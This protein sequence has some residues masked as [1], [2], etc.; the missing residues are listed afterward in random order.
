[1]GVHVLATFEANGS[2]SVKYYSGSPCVTKQWITTERVDKETLASYSCDSKRYTI[3]LVQ[4]QRYSLGFQQ[5][6]QCW[7]YWHLRRELDNY[8][9]GSEVR[10]QQ[11]TQGEAADAKQPPVD[12]SHPII[13]RNSAPRLGWD[14]PSDLCVILDFMDDGDLRSLLNKYEKFG[15]PVGFNRQKATI[16]LRVC[17]ALTYLHSLSSPVVHRDLKS[18]NILLD[19]AM[20]AK[21]TDFVVS[22]EHVDRTMTAGVGTP[23][24]MA[25][26]VVLG[27]KYDVKADMFLFGVVLSELDLHLLPYAKQSNVEISWLWPTEA[28][29]LQRITTGAVRVEFSASSSPSIV[30]L[31]LCIA[32]PTSTG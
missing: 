30:E 23:L 17:H 13:G 25:P 18:R 27:E 15:Q 21:L 31:G 1:M 20:N 22:R 7:H 3:H 32:G 2:A 5:L 12:D 11:T 14:S 16:G 8:S 29:L 9:V 6:G 24:R 4:Q 19:R 10:A 28:A 26:E